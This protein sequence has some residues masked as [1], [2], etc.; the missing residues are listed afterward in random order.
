MNWQGLQ[1]N[2]EQSY[3]FLEQ[4][5]I[6]GCPD[7]GETPIRPLLKLSTGLVLK[8]ISHSEQNRLILLLPRRQVW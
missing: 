6:G 2:F 1:R 4:V 8:A 3:D 5:T 7:I